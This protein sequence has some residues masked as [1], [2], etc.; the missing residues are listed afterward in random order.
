MEVGEER[1]REVVGRTCREVQVR[2]VDG[3]DEAYESG[4][5]WNSAC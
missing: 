4:L 3:L 1:G 5:E 2:L